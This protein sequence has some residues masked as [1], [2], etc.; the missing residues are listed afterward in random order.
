MFFDLP[1]KVVQW[2]GRLH[3]DLEHSMRLWPCLCLLLLSGCM[4][5]KFHGS[6]GSG[7]MIRSSKWPLL[8]PRHPAEDRAFTLL[9]RA[10]DRAGFQLTIHPDAPNPVI[11][12]PFGLQFA[13]PAELPGPKNDPEHYFASFASKLGNDATRMRPI[14]ESICASA[15]LSLWADGAHIQVK[16]ASGK[17]LSGYIW[18]GAR[19]TRYDANW[20]NATPREAAEDLCRFF[21]YVTIDYAWG[22]ESVDPEEGPATLYLTGFDLDDWQIVE[23][24]AAKLYFAVHYRSDGRIVLTAMTEEETAFPTPGLRVIQ[25]QAKLSADD[26]QRP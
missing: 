25:S 5:L 18:T 2:H 11:T 6:I 20:T 21:P 17:Q 1:C 26:L 8:P 22:Q 9:R 4:S 16:A 3:P 12:C 7:V 15:G 13:T 23:L 19:D 24:L 10:A 14:I